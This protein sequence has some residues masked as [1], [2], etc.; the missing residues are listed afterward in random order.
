MKKFHPIKRWFTV[1]ILSIFC[2]KTICAQPVINSFS[3]ASGSI[4]ST[5]I[6]TG[7]NFS[8]TPAGNIVYFGAEQAHVNTATSTALN[9]TVPVG[10][11][12]EPLSVTVNHLSAYAK[13]PF[14]VTFQGSH[15]IDSSSF[16]FRI[17]FNSGSYVF[18]VATADFDGDGNTDVASMN[19]SDDNITIFNNTG[20]LRFLSLTLNVRLN[21]DEN[22][23][24]ITVA[25]IDGD[26]KK[27]II[28]TEDI[29]RKIAIYRNTSTPGNFSFEDK[30][31]YGTFT[32]P[33]NV[34]AGDIDGDGKPDLLVTNNQDQTVSVFRNTT[35][36]NII[37]LAA[38]VNFSTGEAPYGIAAQDVDGD[39]KADM[40]VGN[41][42]SNSVS[43]FLNTSTV[44]NIAFAAKTDFTTGSQPYGIGVADVDGDGKADII[45][46]NLDTTTI[47]VLRNT[48][49][50]G[51]TTFAAKEDVDIKGGANAVAVGDIDG[52]GKPDIAVSNSSV[53]M[54]VIKNTS[55]AGLLSFQPVVQYQLNGSANCIALADINR[56]GT[57]D[58]ITGQFQSVSVLR[59]VSKPFITSFSPS[60]GISGTP[61]T[62]HGYGFLTALAV[63][64]GDSA[65]LSF[66][67]NSDTVITAIVGYGNSGEV[68]VTTVDGIYTLD[69]FTYIPPPVITS[70]TPIYGPLGTTVTIKGNHFVASPDSNTVYFGAVK[71]TVLTATDTLVTVNIKAGTSYK[72]ISLTCNRLTAT[73]LLAFDVT[74]RGAK[75]TF[76]ANDFV[77][78]GEFATADFPVDIAVAD[79]DGD[80]KPDFITPDAGLA[81]GISVLRNTSG[82]S[83]TSFA[84][85]IDYALPFTPRYITTADFDGDGRQDV[86]VT[87]N[88]GEDNLIKIFQN[89]NTA[90]NINLTDGGTFSVGY[91]NYPNGIAA[92][93]L[94]GDGKPDVAVISGSFITII[95]NTG[96]NGHI[97]FGDGIHLGSF[98]NGNKVFINDFDGDGKADVAAV[99]NEGNLSL[100]RNIG[101]NG[102][103]SFAPVLQFNAGDIA[104]AVKAGDFDGDGKPDIVVADRDFNISVFRN[105]SVPGTISFDA[106]KTYSLADNDSL[107]SGHPI[108]DI[109]VADLDGDGKPEI[110]AVYDSP[111]I[112]SVLKNDC[113]P[114]NISFKHHVEYQA[115]YSLFNLATADVTGDGKAD[116]IVVE[117]NAPAIEVL[118]NQ[119]Q[120]VLAVNLFNFKGLVT[121]N[122]VV[123]NW[124]SAGT[125]PVDS[126]QVQRSANGINFKTIGT[127]Q[128]LNN[129][130]SYTFTDASPL[131][132]VNY[133]RLQVKEKNVTGITYSGIIT[134]S[135]HKPAVRIYPNPANESLYINNLDAT[136][137]SVL[138]I[139]DAGGKVLYLQKVHQSAVT[140]NVHLLPAAVYFL[141]IT[142][143]GS[144]TVMRFLKN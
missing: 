92:G 56:D 87:G 36:G 125:L 132:G 140:L 33:V 138:S 34:A 45:T 102:V 2:T 28:I 82:A 62:I 38:P 40:I 52:D 55:T 79:L 75:E 7:N 47:S 81:P 50:V 131:Q 22:P 133:Y 76:G 96:I 70:V 121:N 127:V 93:D 136:A 134:E 77:N 9:V 89:A 142:S 37:S 16:A 66:T 106:Q 20:N 69:S 15:S 99:D 104:N 19:Y 118:S 64:F 128:A 5:V 1:I 11:D 58:I 25:D 107:V 71:A 123:L 35:T 68:I 18:G 103:I 61:V 105:I 59:G 112:I 108:A 141:N 117:N 120:T 122:Q 49:S 17:N 57:P 14:L 139:T 86:A 41:Q 90:G 43:V 30:K 114:G 29:S 24:A 42:Y 21:T 116:L 67:I 44:Q 26:G 113:K 130:S 72:T 60:K 51:N 13:L 8:I 98:V 85:H 126:F 48:S 119:I 129:V 31:E 115:H 88:S 91:E 97:S 23:A 144:A 54:A 94:D 143:A 83:I 110:A 46:A 65:A 32:Y 100:Y 6:I 27:D 84:A 78:A 101:G 95:Q 73:W 80:G 3:P 63:N 39:G 124:Q 111:E 137:A 4:G 12:Y 135:L 10:A 74:F 53:Y 109:S